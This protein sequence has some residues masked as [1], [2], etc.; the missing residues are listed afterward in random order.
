MLY[1]QND[2]KEQRIVKVAAAPTSLAVAASASPSEHLRTFLKIRKII[3]AAGVENVNILRLSE[4][5]CE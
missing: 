3:E 2:S 4:M 5:W 1:K